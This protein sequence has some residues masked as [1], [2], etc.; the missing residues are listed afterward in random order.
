MTF[1]YEQQRLSGVRSNLH[2]VEPNHVSSFY[3][4]MNWRLEDGEG[5]K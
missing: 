5:P 3:K 1:L 4:M 2:G